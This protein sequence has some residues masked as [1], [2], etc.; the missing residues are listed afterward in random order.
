[1]RKKVGLTL[2]AQDTAGILTLYKTIE[3]DCV[4]AKDTN[5]ILRASED[6]KMRIYKFRITAVTHSISSEGTHSI[7]ANIHFQF[8]Y[9]SANEMVAI[10]FTD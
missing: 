10:G 6:G 4:P 5:L 7:Y 9:Y 2:L 3:M 1:M 8:E